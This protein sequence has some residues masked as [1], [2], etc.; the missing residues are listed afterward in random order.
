[1]PRHGAPEPIDGLLGMVPRQ[2]AGPAEVLA[3]PASRVDPPPLPLAEQF[4]LEPG[5]A[6]HHGQ[7]EAASGRRGV[8]AEIEDAQV[9]TAL[10]KIVRQKQNVRGGAAETADLRDGQHVTGRQRGDYLVKDGTLGN[11]G[12]P[13]DYDTGRAGTLERIDLSVLG[14]VGG[15]YAGVPDDFGWQ[16]VG[17]PATIFCLPPFVTNKVQCHAR[18]MN[19]VKRYT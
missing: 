17:H 9:N 10:K 5:E 14:L 1:V 18:F 12:R 7:H 6:G 15:R 2:K 11:A 19:S 13:L 3:P 8:D 16:V 4:P